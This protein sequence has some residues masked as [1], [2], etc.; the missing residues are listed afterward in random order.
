MAPS[1]RCAE[2]TP[3]S[4][5]LAVS[6]QCGRIVR[7][8]LTRPPPHARIIA[9]TSRAIPTVPLI[10]GVLHLGY[11]E[12]HRR[13]PRS[14]VRLPSFCCQGRQSTTRGMRRSTLRRRQPLPVPP[15]FPRPFSPTPVYS[16]TWPFM[17][18]PVPQFARHFAIRRKYQ[19]QPQRKHLRADRSSDVSGQSDD[20]LRRRT[21]VAN[22]S[23]LRSRSMAMPPSTTAGCSAATTA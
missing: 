9:S 3:A 8:S 20:Q 19:H 17:T 14:R 2:R 1:P 11:S 7:S 13:P 4:P 18:A 16:R 22:S 10:R 6:Q 21:A 15:R 5:P 23:P 12:N